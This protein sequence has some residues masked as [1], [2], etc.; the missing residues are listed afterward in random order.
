MSSDAARCFRRG[1]R[2]EESHAEMVSNSKIGC[3]HSEVWFEGRPNPRAPSPDSLKDW[4][5]DSVEPVRPLRSQAQRGIQ[6][7][8]AVRQKTDPVHGLGAVVRDPSLTHILPDALGISF[9]R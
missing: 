3:F 9:E 1:R 6:I 4:P 5:Q 2:D 7:E 8:R